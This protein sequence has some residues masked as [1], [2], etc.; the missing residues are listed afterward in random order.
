MEEHRENLSKRAFLNALTG[1]IDFGAKTLVGFIINPIMVTKLGTVSYGAWQVIGQLNSY[2]ATADIRAA[3]SLKYLLARNRTVSSDYELKKTVSKA[4]YANIIFIPVY[5]VLGTV[6]IWF[7]PVVAGVEKDLFGIIRMASSLMVISFIVTQFFFLFESTLHGMNLAYKRIGVRA[8]IT[9]LGGFA[10]AGVLYTGY[11][12][13]GLAAVSIGVSLLTGLT[14]WWIVKKTIP[15]FAFVKVE[16]AEIL[17]FVKLSGW[18]MLL[19]FADLANQ[20]ID[21]I[22]L[23]YFAGPKYVSVYAITKYTT[24][25]A[26]GIAKTVSNAA[27]IGIGKFVGENNREKIATARQQLLSIQW[28]VL[29]VLGAIICAFNESFIF[30]WTHQELYSG[31]LE[32]LLIVCIALLVVLYQV[33][34]SIINFSLNI[35][36]KIA[37]SFISSAVTV[38]LGWVLIPKIQITG[39]LI[40]IFAG[41]LFNVIMFAKM[42]GQTF[43]IKNVLRRLLLSKASVWGLTLLVISSYIGNFVYTHDWLDLVSY[44]FI[45]GA[46]LAFFIWFIVMNGDERATIIQKTCSLR[47]K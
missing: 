20:S 38:L 40:A 4:L 35:K 8:F 17:Q 7:S 37:V 9:I 14:F 18:F 13:I 21:M 26:S 44:I 5:S 27:S 6:I 33:D 2:M 46:I 39:L 23:G 22:L 45:F 32:T 16:I 24:T 29:T 1:V 11:G 43:R 15:W 28:L 12:I 3:T 25:A 36:K 30:L 19:K 42:V 34:S 31:Q 41:S 47:R 10:T